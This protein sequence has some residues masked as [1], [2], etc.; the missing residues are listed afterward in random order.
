MSRQTLTENERIT[1][2]Y[3]DVIIGINPGSLENTGF[4]RF[5]PIFYVRDSG[6][7]LRGRTV[8]QI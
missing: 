8:I 6:K 3:A 2:L 5:N 7:S 4:R 1:A